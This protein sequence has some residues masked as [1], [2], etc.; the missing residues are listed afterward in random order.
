MAE[1]ML[2]TILVVAT[3]T[4]AEGETYRKPMRVQRR[5]WKKLGGLKDILTAEQ[6]LAV[7]LRKRDKRYGSDLRITFAREENIPKSELAVRPDI[8]E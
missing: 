4:D 1:E 6:G 5:H 3:G 8:D 7:W 2:D